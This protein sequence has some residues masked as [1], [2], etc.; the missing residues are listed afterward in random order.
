MDK[1]LHPSNYIQRSHI[2]AKDI[3]IPP[4]MGKKLL[5]DA[6][7]T[8]IRRSSKS[9]NQRL[10]RRTGEQDPSSCPSQILMSFQSSLVGVF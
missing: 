3:E 2:A 8:I 9:V 7:K 5:K 10:L 4:L 1:L 6:K